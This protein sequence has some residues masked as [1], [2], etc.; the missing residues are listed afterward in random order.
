MGGTG[1]EQATLESVSICD[2]FAIRP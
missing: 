1:E 2:T